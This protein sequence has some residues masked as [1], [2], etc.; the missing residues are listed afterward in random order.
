MLEVNK[1]WKYEPSPGP[2]VTAYTTTWNCLNGKYP[3]EDS[4]KSFSWCDK[5]VVVDGG[6]TDGTRELL[7]QLCEQ[8]P[9]LTVYDVPIDESMPGKD[10]NQKAMALAMVDTPMAIQFDVDEYCG[11]F[12]SNWRQL[13]KEM[14]ESRDI[15]SLPVIEPF[16]DRS[17]I[18][19]NKSFTPWKWRIFRVK[20]E[21]SHGIPKNDRLEIDG[22]VYS[23]GGSDG[24]FPI[25]IVTNEMISS[26][27]TPRAT[28]LTKI[29]ES[30]D[31]EAYKEEIT[32]LIFSGEPSIVHL[33]H[34]DL[35][36]KIKHYLS[37]WHK[38][39]CLLYN[40][41]SS[42]PKN[43]VYFPGIAVESVTDEMINEKVRELV[44]TTPHVKLK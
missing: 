2:Q 14:S 3:V 19:M 38:W 7:T 15:L 44:E 5:I 40:K 18:R 28:K 31:K 6:S 20:P 8:Y 35:F 16:G 39:W 9:N 37:S 10:G 13:M 36:N 24:C 22:V 4:I 26:K 25:N 42:D 12:P 21:I 23:K 30:G 34:V 29:K 1:N 27:L 41:D 17:N 11:G 43:N 32:D 33:G